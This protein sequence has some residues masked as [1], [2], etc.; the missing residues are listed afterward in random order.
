MDDVPPM[1]P[2]LWRRCSTLRCAFFRRRSL[3]AASAMTGVVGVLCVAKHHAAARNKPRSTAMH[4]IGIALALA[5]IA[6]CGGAPRSDLQGGKSR[7]DLLIV[8]LGGTNDRFGRLHVDCHDR[9]RKTVALA[10]E[11]AAQ[12]R[13]VRVLTSGGLDELLHLGH[14]RAGAAVQ[15]WELV[16]DA[17]VVRGLPKSALLTPGIPALTTVDEAV[18]T[19]ALIARLSSSSSKAPALEP[20]DAGSADAAGSAFVPRDVV[21]VTSEYHEARAA[22]LFGRALGHCTGLGVSLRRVHAVPDGRTSDLDDAAMRMRREHEVRALRML[23]TEPNGPWLTFL[24]QHG[25]GA[26]NGTRCVRRA[27]TRQ[28]S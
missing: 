13:R 9:L 24:Q 4:G 18:M 27:R 17:L 10:A 8:Q 5:G 12:G 22:H 26:E 6:A 25:G 3:A 28:A 16:S 23:R 19:H 2:D 21:V 1:S 11:A 15:H 14:R 20:R 7:S